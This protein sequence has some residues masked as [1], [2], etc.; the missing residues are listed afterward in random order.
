MTLF[1]RPGAKV[2]TDDRDESR[3]PV[4]PNPPATIEA[5]SRWPLAA[6]L[7]AQTPPCPRGAPA[8]APATLRP[9]RASRSESDAK[10]LVISARAARGPAIP[11]HSRIFARLRAPVRAV[12]CCI[13]A[14]RRDLRVRHV[15]NGRARNVDQLLAAGERIK[16]SQ[17][18]NVFVSRCLVR[19]FLDPP[20]RGVIPK[21]LRLCA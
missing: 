6:P 9:L 2:C 20:H 4:V 15:A 3:Q 5:P 11:T 12:H 8:G 13:T 19:L 7:R 21:P 17:R 18:T 14:A 16:S 10:A 1:P